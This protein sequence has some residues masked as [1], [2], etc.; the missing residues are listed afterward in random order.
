M[1]PAPNPFDDSVFCLIFAWTSGAATV[2]IVKWI[3]DD[4]RKKTLTIN[5][6]I[7]HTLP[8]LF[9]CAMVTAILSG[10]YRRFFPH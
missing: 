7:D 9:G 8:V 10:L 2:F 1:Q 3:R 4:Y 5:R 6:C